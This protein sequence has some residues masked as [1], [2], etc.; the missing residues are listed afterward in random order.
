M[1]VSQRLPASIFRANQ[2]VSEEL[3]GSLNETRAFL[4]LYE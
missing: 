1:E 3:V 2:R 4:K